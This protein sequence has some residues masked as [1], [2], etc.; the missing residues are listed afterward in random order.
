MTPQHSLRTMNMR[1]ASKKYFHSIEFVSHFVYR[2][3]ADLDLRISLRITNWYLNPGLWRNTM[4]ASSFIHCGTLLCKPDDRYHQ[5]NHS[6]LFGGGGYRN[7]ARA[8]MRRLVR[9]YGDCRDIKWFTSHV[10]LLP[11]ALV[12]GFIPS[13]L[14]MRLIPGQISTVHRE[15]TIN[16][17]Q[18]ILHHDLRVLSFYSR[19]PCIYN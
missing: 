10:Y 9:K 13:E 3:S 4:I 18:T 1:L 15:C 5:L 19:T 7:S 6:A 2:C 17:S 8:S 12:S 14:H 16:R 11:W